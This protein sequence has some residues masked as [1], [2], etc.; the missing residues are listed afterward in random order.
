[1]TRAP[2]TV[3][4]LGFG[5]ALLD[6]LA[7]VD[8]DFRASVPGRKGGTELLD[9]QTQAAI[10]QRLPQEALR[11]PGGAAANTVVG[12]AKLGGRAA[13]LAKIGQDEV[14]RFYRQ[15]LQDAGVDTSAFKHCANEDTGRCLSLITPD[16]ERTMRTYMGAAAT[17]RADELRAEDFRGHSHFYCEGYALFDR[18]L[19]FRALKLARDAGMTI[20]LDLAAP[21]IVLAA[22]D[23]LPA[24]LRDYVHAVFANEQEA[25]AFCGSTNPE[26]GLD[27]L[28]AH[29]PL[30]VLKLGRQG[31]RLRE[32]NGEP[33]SVPA[34]EVQAV[35]STGA[36]DLWAAGFL[37]GW[38]QGWPLHEAAALGAKVAAA[39]VQVTGAV[40]PDQVWAQ[41]RRELPS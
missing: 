27:A 28:A 18:E 33:I 39:V 30:A 8:E 32:G 21:E 4:V 22:Q 41:I 25:A 12:Y 3:S 10:I 26:V 19:I 38:L 20:C 35:D 14:G 11:A 17:L 36:G 37:Y 29:C 24:L 7:H 5:S 6:V 2:A 9:C 23:I 13:M 40:I 15:A 31:L 34:Y 16:S 1:M